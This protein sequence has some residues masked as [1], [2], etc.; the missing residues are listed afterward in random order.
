MKARTALHGLLLALIA[1]VPGVAQAPDLES[2]DLVL[3]SVPD[4][5]V[6]KVSAVSIGREAFIQLYR[7]ELARVTQ[8]TG[9]DVPDGGK[10]KLAMWCIGTLIEQELL[11][12]EAVRRQITLPAGVAE[13]AWKEQFEQIRQRLS[14][15]GKKEIGEARVLANLGFESRQDMLGKLERGLLIE[16]MRAT[17]I[18]DSGVTATDDEVSEHYDNEK[19]RF[20]RPDTMHLRQIFIRVSG[21]GPR[22]R[23]QRE[24][25]RT[26]ADD[27][28]ARIQSGQSFQ[29]LVRTVSE[30]PG[31]GTGGDLGPAPIDRLPPFL[32]DPALTMDPGEIS[33]VIESEYGFH[34]IQ[35]VEIVPAV[36]A[37]LE[38]AAPAIKNRLL[39]EKEAEAVH[40][41]CDTLVLKDYNVKVFLELE[42]TLSLNPDYAELEL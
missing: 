1:A 27:T 8:L 18:R 3:K 4:G 31:S 17:V 22:A 38:R 28:L 23:Q 11:Y 14:R 33:G 6:A 9:K 16:K 37:T 21:N 42:K 36:Q 5:P 41:Y 34:I 39:A 40:D 15:E 2:M 10:V 12:Q 29:G 26:R 25:A 30:A 35:L 7:A 32:V 19:D 13:Q 20:A 24:D